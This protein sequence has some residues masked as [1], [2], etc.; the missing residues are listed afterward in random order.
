MAV[1][2][3][4]INSCAT[5]THEPFR[6]LL[7]LLPI[8]INLNL[9]LSHP[10]PLQQGGSQNA[11]KSV[12]SEQRA[13]KQGLGL[14]GLGINRGHLKR[15]GDGGS[16]TCKTLKTKSYRTYEPLSKLLVS[17]LIAPIVVPYI[18]PLYNPPFK[19]FRPWVI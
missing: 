17:P 2:S 5:D 14:Q 11:M 13:I 6:T 16:S 19:E 7:C 12:E 8:P 10:P 4:N 1:K 18:I 9:P 15:V 3:E